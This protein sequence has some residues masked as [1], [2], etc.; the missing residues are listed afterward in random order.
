MERAQTRQEQEQKQRFDKNIACIKM[1][2]TLQKTRVIQSQVER[3]NEEFGY[4]VLHK[5]LYN[6]SPMKPMVEMPEDGKL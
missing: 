1:C 2:D 4:Q 6:Q 3:D 5:G